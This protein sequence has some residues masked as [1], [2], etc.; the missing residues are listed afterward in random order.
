MTNKELAK[1]LLTSQNYKT[2]YIMDACA[3]MTANETI[4]KQPRL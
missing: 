4:Y 2:L 3:P 1:S